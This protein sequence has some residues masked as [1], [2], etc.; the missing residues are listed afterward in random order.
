[1]LYK[2][3]MAEILAKMLFFFYTFVNYFVVYIVCRTIF[4]QVLF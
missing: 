2:K 4:L 1:M 3:I